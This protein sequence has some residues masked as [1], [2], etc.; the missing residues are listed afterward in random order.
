VD[1]IYRGFVNRVAAGRK[2]TYEQVDE[3]A[4]GR[5]WL[6]SQAVDRGLVDKL[7]GLDTA[8]E[9]V[10]VKAKL[11]STDKIALVPY[12]PRR[13]LF[14]VLMNYSD[15]STI[16]EAKLD[17]ALSRIPGGRWIRCLMDGGPLAVMPYF[18][19]VSD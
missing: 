8:I 10:R 16:A 14:D 11:P 4:Q 1:A 17:A 5:V 15:E 3:I 2:K 18:V 13:S 19:V 6:G 7:G 9:L 12:P